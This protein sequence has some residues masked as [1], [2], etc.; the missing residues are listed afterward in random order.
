MFLR[1]LFAIT[2]QN[3]CVSKGNKIISH[4]IL[5]KIGFYLYAFCT[6]TNKHKKIILLMITDPRSLSGAIRE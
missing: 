1:S 5:P 3:N 2:A 4:I 6:L